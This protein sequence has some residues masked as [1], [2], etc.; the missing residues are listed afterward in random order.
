MR[1]GDFSSKIKNEG[2]FLNFEKF[3]PE[4]VDFDISF[5][6]HSSITFGA[7]EGGGKFFQKFDLLHITFYGNSVLPAS[8]ISLTSAS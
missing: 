6:G 3:E 1:R 4:M 8:L 7:G 5:R 2:N